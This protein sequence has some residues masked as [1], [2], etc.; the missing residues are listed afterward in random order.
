[1]NEWQLKPLEGWMIER[2]EERFAPLKPAVDFREGTWWTWDSGMY[3][4]DTLSPLP[5][6]IGQVYRIERKQVQIFK[7][8][9]V[10]HIEDPS[11]YVVQVDW[12][13]Y[14]KGN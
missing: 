12:D 1:M 9:R 14:L 6:V 5:P 13:W 11:Y 10:E 2:H 7:V 3:I 4:G 8:L